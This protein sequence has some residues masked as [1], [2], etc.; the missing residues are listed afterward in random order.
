M[1]II[2]IALAFLGYTAFV[3]FALYVACKLAEEVGP[4][5]ETFLK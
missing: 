2:Y 5:D 1:E 3:G 4:N